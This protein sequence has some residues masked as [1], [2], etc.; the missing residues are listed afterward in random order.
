MT[1]A[2]GQPL[3][4]GFATQTT[5]AGQAGAILQGGSVVSQG[6]VMVQQGMM[7][8]SQTRMPT[9]LAGMAAGEYYVIALDDIDPEDML[10]P[11]V[12]ERLAASSVRFTV[13]F[14]LPVEVPVRRMTLADIIR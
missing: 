11:E 3:N 5:A 14:D 2:D 10:D 1:T 4:R 7:T 13:S 9:G 6:G 12:L 8:M